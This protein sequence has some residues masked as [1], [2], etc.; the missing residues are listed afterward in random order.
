MTNPVIAV[1]GSTGQQGGATARA[2]LSAGATVR[3]LVRDPE[4]RPRVNSLQPAR[5]W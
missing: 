1:V 5:S 4:N 3:A 2:L